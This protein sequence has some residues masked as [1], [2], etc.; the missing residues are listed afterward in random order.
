M[1]RRKQNFF[2]EVGGAMLRLSHRVP[3]IG[4]I[5][6]VAGGVGWWDFRAHGD[7]PGARGLSI[8]CAVIG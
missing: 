5:L 3:L 2:A 4:A 1:A 8:A 7:S 6:A